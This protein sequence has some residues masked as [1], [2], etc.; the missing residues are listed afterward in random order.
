MEPLLSDNAKSYHGFEQGHY[1]VIPNVEEFGLSRS[2][3]LQ[4][5]LDACIEVLRGIN[6]LDHFY[7]RSAEGHDPWRV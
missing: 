5:L 4:E 1:I 7:I 2:V 6:S 3:I